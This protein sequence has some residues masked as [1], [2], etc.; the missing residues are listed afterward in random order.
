MKKHCDMGLFKL[1]A[2]TWLI[3]SASFLTSCTQKPK[4][5][6]QSEEYTVYSDRVVQ[7]A[8][9][10]HAVSPTQLVSNYRSTASDNFSSLITFKFC[11]NEKDVELPSGADHW[12]IIDSEH[13]TPILRFGEMP[14]SMPPKPGTML[15]AN[16]AFTFRVD[17]SSVLTAFEEKGYYE[18]FNGNRI[19][20]D[21]FKAFQIAGGSEPLSWDFSNL[22]EKGLVLEDPDE[23]GIYELT[24]VLNPVDE[25]SKVEKK[26]I[27]SLNT[28]TKPQYESD[29]PIVDALYN[30]ALEEA[31][32]NIEADS[33]L[34]TGAKW[35]GVWTR[36]VSYSTLLAFAFHEPEVAKI[37]LMKKVK[38]GRI[39]QDT[40]SGGAW[41]VSS[42][43]TTWSLAAWEIFLVTGD[44]DW[45]EQS[46]EIISNSLEDDYL[47]LK[48]PLTG[49]YRGE[50]S[51]LDWR[52]QTYP[53]WMS[54]T[55]I[56]V[57]EN[58][59]TNAVHYRAHIILAEMA[60]LLDEPYKVYLERAEEIR[61]GINTYLWM[62]KEGY[63][64]QYLYGRSY[65]SPSPRFEA[66]GESLAI[67][68]DVTDEEK[69]G[70]II[71]QSP[72]TAFGATCIFPQIP[73]IPS[74]HNNAI[75]PFVQSFWNLAAAKAANETVLTHGLAAV[76]R[77]AALFL[78]NYENFVAG[79]GDFEGTEINSDRM[80]WSM[81][82]NLAMVH[83]LFMGISFE[84]DG[85]HFDPVIPKEYGGRK[86]LSNFR[87]RDA[88]L[89][90]TVNG[91]GNKI[92]SIK[93]DGVT[94]TGNFLPAM[95]SGT[96]NIE[97]VMENNRFNEAG[98]N[99]VPNRFSLPNP[100]VKLTGSVLEWDKVAGADSYRV[101]C[102]GEL[103]ETTS[104]LNF[105]VDPD[106]YGQYQLAAVDETGTASFLSEP[107]RVDSENKEM[108]FE[109]EAYAVRSTRGYTNY[110][111]SGFVEISQIENRKIVIPLEVEVAGTYKLDIRYS[112]GT[113][114]WNTD[115]NCAGRSLSVNGKYEGVMVFPQRGSDEWSDWGFSNEIEVKLK[116]GQNEVLLSFEAWNMNMDGQINEAMLDYIRLI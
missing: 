19:A 24:L 97:I 30:L 93:S 55:D 62:E 104:D 61:K 95:I 96:H 113:G 50:S 82:G 107:I 17:M 71:S 43:R 103:I 57:S 74:Y 44:Q 54:N 38:R 111:G 102:N 10:T 4:I 28:A 32:M 98:I 115:N 3:I 59:G 56:F 101:I 14:D 109:F 79:N 15:P 70:S 87:Y 21:D 8:Y 106:Q 47:T 45:L 2:I 116:K 31:M 48:S 69:A 65:L 85:I 39:I 23:D 99:L 27:L 81:A 51:F 37:S 91:Y 25:T 60:K 78:T 67:L 52:E 40:G 34:R 72:L 33:T 90:I 100:R 73:G 5:L 88:I 94:M 7:G 1:K 63:Y 83:R 41:P 114:P 9:E 49:M 42:D 89:N 12:V 36:D 110:S 64:A 46:Y 92:S 22:D 26:W 35:G 11:I 13:E 16:Y 29:Q 20:A 112:N 6:Y 68:F 108:I 84:V 86:T 18:A 105:K 53:K 77:P 76:Y 66:L 80:L 75:W 58:L